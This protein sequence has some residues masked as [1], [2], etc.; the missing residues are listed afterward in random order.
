MISGIT[1]PSANYSSTSTPAT[2]YPL[3]FFAA[4]SMFCVLVGVPTNL[5]SLSYFIQKSRRAT[6]YVS[7][8]HMFNNLVDLTMC[9][10]YLPS[11]VTLISGGREMFFSV[12]L[13]CIAWG[14]LQQI[15]ARLSV[16][17]IGLMSVLRAV[18]MTLPFV[19]L[20]P[21]HIVTPILSYLVLLMI[22]QTIPLWFGSSYFFF[23]AAGGCGWSL[24]AIFPINTPEF[25]GLTL[26]LVV[27][28]YILPIF[29]IIASCIISVYQLKSTP[30]CCGNT[31]NYDKYNN[32]LIHQSLKTK[33]S[34]TLTI[35]ILTGL[36]IFFNLPYCIMLALDQ[37]SVLSEY[38]WSYHQGSLTEDQFHILHLA[39][40]V[41]SIPLN[42]TTIYFSVQWSCCPNFK[43]DIWSETV[44]AGHFL[45]HTISGLSKG[46]TYY[47]TVQAGNIKGFGTATH[48]VKCRPSHW[49][50]CN[51]RLPDTITH[52][53][54]ISKCLSDMRSNFSS[55]F[56]HL[57]TAT[58]SKTKT[59]NKSLS[60]I[61]SSPKF[62]KTL[63]RRLNHSVESTSWSQP[64]IFQETFK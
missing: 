42:I 15:T 38:S 54:T 31:A 2:D 37:V 26:L 10:L 9:L 44:P 63:N 21:K 48:P 11:A 28:E 64:C 47:F 57:M 17:C 60:R 20:S 18:C 13:L 23:P 52:L 56:P 19:R 14:Y 41:Y 53:S 33:R 6:S 34:A 45:S 4:I 35:I 27:F 3:P 49:S 39:I 12:H 22:Q 51:Q 25:K 59:R 32:Q 29:P 50:D 1:P 55:L 62:V 43:S 8:F 16:F 36:Y 40:T 30:V 61:F 58:P 24:G 5:L 7:L 46:T